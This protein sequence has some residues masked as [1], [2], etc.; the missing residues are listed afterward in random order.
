MDT[1]KL[2]GEVRR[3]SSRHYPF[4][5]TCFAQGKGIYIKDTDGKVYIDA[6]SGYGSVGLG[7]NHPRITELLRTLNTPDSDGW[8]PVNVVP[9][10]FSTPQL[11]ELL[12]SICGMF[13]YDKALVTNGGVEANEAAIKLMR[14]WGYTQ[15]GVPKDKARIVVCEGN[16]HGRTT[17]VVGFS[18]EPAYRDLFGPYVDDAFITIPYGDP[19]ALDKVLREDAATGSP[20]IV[21]FLVEPIQGEGGVR[22]PRPDYL[23]IC[24]GLCDRDNVVFCADEIQTGLGR[25]GKL[26]ASWHANIRP[27]LVVLGK[28]LGAGKQPVAVVLGMN[29]FMVFEPGDHGSTY[30]GNAAGMALAHEALSIIADEGLC[31][32]ATKMGNHLL[33]AI[34][35]EVRSHWLTDIVTDVRGKG[36]MIGIE[37]ADPGLS[38]TAIKSLLAHGVMSKDA[39]G[40]IRITPALIITKEECDELASRIGKALL[41]LAP[42]SP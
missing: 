11:A 34:R 10:A 23:A 17:T 41:S 26:L 21:G 18:S 31:E 24:K 14:K 25:T 38:G 13:G 9:N 27:D 8:A 40:V 37:L 42:V 33:R 2:L 16:F 7:H 15:K 39:H 30:G 35:R 3:F 19:W 29:E 6:A 12:A 32:H 36:L 28:T 22:I 20:T 4:Y 1:K 5:P